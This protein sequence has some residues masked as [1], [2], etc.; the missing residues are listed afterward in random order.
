MRAYNYAC[1]VVSGRIQSA[2]LQDWLFSSSNIIIL[3]LDDFQI[4][5][6]LAIRLCHN[7]MH[8]IYRSFYGPQD[9]YHYSFSY[10]FIDH[11]FFIVLIHL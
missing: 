3:L 7:V 6:S 2:E 4:S 9:L 1:V 8:I 11:S 5:L 10:Q